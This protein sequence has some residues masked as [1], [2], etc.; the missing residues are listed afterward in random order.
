MWYWPHLDPKQA[1]PRRN[2]QWVVAGGRRRRKLKMTNKR[3]NRHHLRRRV[4]T[5]RKTRVA[6][7]R[8]LPAKPNLRPPCW[9]CWPSCPKR[10]QWTPPTCSR[11]ERKGFGR[12]PPRRVQKSNKRNAKRNIWRKRPQVLQVLQVRPQL[13]LNRCL[14][15][16]HQQNQSRYDQLLFFS[17]NWR[18]IQPGFFGDIFA[19]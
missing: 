12:N 7:Q 19:D 11:A 5:N 8:H 2:L 13:Q 3:S 17:A 9:D 10:T 18:C 14:C 15:Q 4:K 6:V 1:T 16:F